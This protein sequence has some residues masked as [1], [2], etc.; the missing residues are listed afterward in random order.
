MSNLPMESRAENKK[1]TPNTPGDAPCR[2][3]AQPRRTR[4]AS[5][6]RARLLQAALIPV[7]A[8]SRV[9][10]VARVACA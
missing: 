2:I 9:A 6:V 10:R 7:V 1:P 8:T 3:G 4:V 5:I